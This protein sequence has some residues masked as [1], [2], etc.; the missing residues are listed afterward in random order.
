MPIAKQVAKNHSYTIGN[1]TVNNFTILDDPFSTELRMQTKENHMLYPQWAI[2]LCLDKVYLGGVT[3][4]RVLMWA[5]TAEVTYI[6]ALGSL[7][8]PV[9]EDDVSFPQENSTLQTLDT[10][11]VAISIVT[12]IGIA[13]AIITI[14]KKHK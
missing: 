6:A 7:G 8:S 14:K 2:R 3:E 5:D 1:T 11:L 12:V 4:I 9:V 10:W 13:L